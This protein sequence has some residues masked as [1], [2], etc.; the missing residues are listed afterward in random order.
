MEK[1][2][3]HIALS[4]AEFLHYYN[5]SARVLIVTAEDG[6]T[7][8]LPAGRF[9]QFVSESGIYGYFQIVLDDQNK[10]ESITQLSD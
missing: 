4:S 9:R 3:F 6:R 1:I 10:L 8:Q 7:I 5:G 2:R